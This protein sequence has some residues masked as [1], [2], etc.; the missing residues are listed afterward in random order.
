ML[1]LTGRQ[2]DGAIMKV[3]EAV[4]Q[5]G[6]VF[7]AEYVLTHFDGIIG[8]YTYEETVEDGVILHIRIIM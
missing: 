6:T 4:Y 3:L 7:L 8:P 1:F 2:Y 5:H